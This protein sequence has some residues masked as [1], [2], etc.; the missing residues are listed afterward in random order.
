MP[1]TAAIIII[2]NEILSGRIQDTN[3][4]YLASELRALGVDVRRIAVVPDDVDAIAEEVS[5]CSRAYDFV[6]TAGGVGPTH[7]DVTMQGIARGFGV[8]TVVS[9]VMAD[10]IRKRCGMEEGNSSMKMAE[11]PEGAEVVAAEG[12]RFPPVVINNV[13]VFPGIPEFLKN[14]FSALK[15][16]FRSEPFALRK[17][18]VNEEECFIARHLD[19]VVEEFGDVMVGSYPRVNEPDYK[20][21]V[22]LES[23]NADSLARALERL[24][25]LL[26]KGVVVRTE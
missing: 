6:F 10:I 9:P 3:S 16:R 15:E 8:K 14:K 12:L 1:K 19:T 23:T 22:T 13:Y 5:A 25:G 2:G 11:V 7:D 26:P 18:Y 24:M 21:V 17:V 4:W 20:V